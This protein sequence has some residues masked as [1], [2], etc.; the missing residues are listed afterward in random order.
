MTHT[1]ISLSAQRAFPITALLALTAG[2]WGAVIFGTFHYDDFA[3]VVAD[4]ATHELAVWLSRLGSGIRPLTRTTYF[5]DASL[6]GMRAGGFLFTNLVLHLLTVSGVYVLARRRLDVGAAFV[7]AAV[8]ALQPAH[9]E[10][11]AYVSGRSTGLMACLLV[12]A[13]VSHER[14]DARVSWPSLALFVAACLAKEVALVFPLLVWLWEA[15]RPGRDA[16]HIGRRVLPYAL[17]AGI[18]AALVFASPRFRELVGYSLALRAPVENLALQFRAV[19]EMLS[20]WFRPGA[21]TLDHAFSL[22]PTFATV[23]LSAVAW[24]ALLGLAFASRRR[25]SWVWFAIAWALVC[26]LPT[27]SVLAKLDV[28]TEKP[29]YLAWL[30]PALAAGWLWSRAVAKVGTSRW[31]WRQRALSAVVATGLALAGATCVWR[32]RVWSDDRRLWSEAI[33]HNPSGSRV[34][35]NVGLAFAAD[36]PTLAAAAFRR[37]VELD[38]DNR[39]ALDNLKLYAVLEER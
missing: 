4:P 29:L 20:L 13:L 5:L 25:T 11:V 26:L 10:T 33:A 2:A 34:W 23:A 18:G 24:L 28:I 16:R 8:F 39:Q 15:S 14:N 6:W 22:E 32:V 17:A 3:N 35:N 30:G 37:A 1:R 31:H 19:P 21:L 27:Q 7:A 38:P 9:A 36:D 12:W